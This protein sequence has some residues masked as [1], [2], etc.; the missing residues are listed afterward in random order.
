MPLC[1]HL[2]LLCMCYGKNPSWVM[3]ATFA[4]ARCRVGP[5][6]MMARSSVVPETFACPGACLVRGA[7]WAPG[8]PQRHFTLIEGC[9]KGLNG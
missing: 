1:S 5:G 8:S 6:A 7:T 9:L 2:F 4:D 3:E